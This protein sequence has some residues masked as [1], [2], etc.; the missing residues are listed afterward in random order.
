MQRLLTPSEFDV[1]AARLF[2]NVSNVDASYLPLAIPLC[3]VASAL[4]WMRSRRLNLMSLG[5]YA[6]RSLGLDHRRELFIVLFLVAV[7]MATSTALVGPMTFFGFLVATLAY[8]FA[9]SH[10]HRLIFPMAVVGAFTI[11]AGAYFVMRNVFFAQGMVSILIELVGGIVF[12]VVILR[13]DRL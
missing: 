9:D 5:P 12:L 7:L 4:L 6:A 1:L 11:L 8:Q 2:G 13:K 10:D 3:V